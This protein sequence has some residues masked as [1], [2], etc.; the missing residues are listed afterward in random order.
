MMKKNRDRY[1]KIYSLIHE[2]IVEAY[3]SHDLPMILEAMHKAGRVSLTPRRIVT[4]LRGRITSKL[5]ETKKSEKLKKKIM[6]CLRVLLYLRDLQFTG[7]TSIEKA[8]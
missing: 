7:L 1:D 6:E 2:Y 5:I 4:P 3:V 8:S